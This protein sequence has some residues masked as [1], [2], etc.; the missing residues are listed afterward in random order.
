[1]KISVIDL[2]FNSIKLVNY[3]VNT[4]NNSY[5][6]YEQHGAMV[7]LGQDF[8]GTLAYEPIQRTIR[9]LQLFRDIIHLEH[10]RHVIS[11]ATSAVREANNN[12]DFLQEV[13][14]KTGFKFTILTGKEEALYSYLGALQSTCIPT[15]LFFDLGG[16][17]LELVYSENYKIKKVISLPLGTLRL[18]QAYYEIEGRFSKKNYSKL[19][20]HI[21]R[22]LPDRKE[23]DISLDTTLVGVGGTLRAISRYHQESV[24]YPLQKIHNYRVY[25]DDIRTITNTFRNMSPY[26][27]AEIGT[28]G[29]NRA[30][31]IT[32]GSCIMKVLMEELEFENILVSARG[33][34]EGVLSAFLCLATNHNLHDFN[35]TQIQNLV[36]Y[37]CKPEKIPQYARAI[38][39][40]FYNLGLLKEREYEIL[41]HAIKIMSD[42]PVVTNLYNIFYIIFD[43]D[44][45]HFSHREQLILALSIVRTKKAKAANALF[46][47]FSLI[48]QTQNKKSIEKISCC[49]SLSMI[50]ERCKTRV[51]VAKYSQKEIEMTFISGENNSLPIILLEEVVNSIKKAFDISITYSISSRF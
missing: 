16:G 28:I 41:V 27:I 51:R 15:A 47:K 4:K 25:F 3:F 40:L 6:A 12:K 21:V 5:H 30:G 20:E 29:S 23:L 26:E 36:K 9:A 35:L 8:S 14:K 1:M 48:L 38:V 39:T 34:R 42:L 2:G 17:S 13:L 33:L 10:V 7:R 11:I 45:R 44:I 49:L 32:V 37:S 50:L 22:E 18:S 46:T 19:E 24:G 31:T 43:E